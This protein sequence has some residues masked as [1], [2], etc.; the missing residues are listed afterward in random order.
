MRPLQP[1]CLVRRGRC[2]DCWAHSL[3]A[4]PASLAPA[5]LCWGDRAG[6]SHHSSARV[7]RCTAEDRCPA[8]GGG[9]GRDVPKHVEPAPL[10]HRTSQ[11]RTLL[12]A[13]MKGVL[14]IL[15]RLMDS[16][17]C[18]SRL[19]I[20]S[21]TRMAMSHRLLPL[22]RRLLKDSCPAGSPPNEG[23]CSCPRCRGGLCGRCL[24][25]WPDA[26]WG[27]RCLN[28]AASGRQLE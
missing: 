23:L 8:Q 19:C 3:C 24:A 9:G 10:S 16:M 11:R 20:R 12:S 17:V 18:G 22:L 28:H 21:I 27:H 15:S 1:A 4:A 26:S 13:M 2:C 6:G 14:R 7:P 5:L 25:A